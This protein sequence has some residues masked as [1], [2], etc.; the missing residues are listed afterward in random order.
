DS[1]IS[2]RTV[3]PG[4]KAGQQGQATDALRR[5]HEQRPPATGHEGFD[6]TPPYDE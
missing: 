3:R 5:A 1:V 6:Q 2:A 4:G